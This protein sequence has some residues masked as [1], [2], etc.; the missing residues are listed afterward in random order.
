MK[1]LKLSLIIILLSGCG[2]DREKVSKCKIPDH[3]MY[4]FVHDCM[5]NTNS[6]MKTCENKSINFYCKY[7]HRVMK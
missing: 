2:P 5:T 3:L 7:D 1:I 4:A 6:Y